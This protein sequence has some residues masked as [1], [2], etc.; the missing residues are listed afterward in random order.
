M[1]MKRSG[2]INPFVVVGVVCLIVLLPLIF[3]SKRGPGAYAADFLTALGSGNVDQLAQ[4]SV[5]GDHNLEER[6]KLWQDSLNSSK[7]FTFTWRITDVSDLAED[8][9][10]IKTQERR[11]L[12]I[13]MGEDEEPH[14]FTMVKTPDGWKALLDGMDRDI[15]PYLPRP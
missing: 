12:Q 11:N 6:K 13:K 15:Y 9:A 1:R 3:I 8:R 7:Y 5:I 10:A 14:E 4:L 2:R